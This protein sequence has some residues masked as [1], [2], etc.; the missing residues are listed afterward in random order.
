MFSPTTGARVRW[1][2]PAARRRCPRPRS[3]EPGGPGSTWGGPG[4]T[5]GGWKRLERDLL[6]AGGTAGAAA[7]GGRCLLTDGAVQP[8]EKTVTQLAR[9]MKSKFG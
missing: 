2:R 6:L 9:I 7:A 8:S 4:S 1:S 3:R 5:R